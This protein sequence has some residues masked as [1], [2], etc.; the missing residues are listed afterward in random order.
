M[1]S[2]YDPCNPF[3]YKDGIF[4]GVDPKRSKRIRESIEY[5]VKNGMAWEHVQTFHSHDHLPSLQSVLPII[6]KVCQRFYHKYGEKKFLVNATIQHNG[7]K[8]EKGNAV[9]L[10]F[11]LEKRAGS[12]LINQKERDGKNV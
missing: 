3:L 1:S 12:D 9:M 2:R 4:F 6:R 11:H 8:P 5:D 10:M 7:L